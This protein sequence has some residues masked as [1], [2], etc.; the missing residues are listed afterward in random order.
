MHCYIPQEEQEETA[1]S[2]KM[3][4]QALALIFQQVEGD[5]IY[6]LYQICIAPFSNNRSIL[7]PPVAINEVR[8]ILVELID[9]VQKCIH[10]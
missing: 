3:D 2:D 10:T 1:Q 4:V 9:R 8:E 5:G 6:M 7:F